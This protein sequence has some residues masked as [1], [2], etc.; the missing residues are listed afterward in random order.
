MPTSVELPANFRSI[1][2]LSN[3]VDSSLSTVST[4][5]QAA[6][7]LGLTNI[8]DSLHSFDAFLPP[9]GSPPQSL[10]S[11]SDAGAIASP[12]HY[13]NQAQE[14][15]GKDTLKS[16]STL[17]PMNE[18][19]QKLMDPN[20]EQQK[21]LRSFSD[22]LSNF[23]L[24]DIPPGEANSAKGLG[25]AHEAKH[26]PDVGIAHEAKYAREIGIGHEAKHAPDFKFAP[27][28]KYRAPDFKQAPEFKFGDTPL[29]KQTPHQAGD[30]KIVRFDDPGFTPKISG[31]Q[32]DL[33]PGFS[34]G[35]F[36]EADRNMD[37]GFTP[38]ALPEEVIGDKW[39]PTDPGFTPKIADGPLRD[40]DPGFMPPEMPGDA[41]SYKPVFPGDSGFTPKLPTDANADKQ[42]PSDPG[43]TP[44]AD[45]T[46]DKA[47]PSDPG[48]IPA[49]SNSIGDDAQRIFDLQN[50][51]QNIVSLNKQVSEF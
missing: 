47:L 9:I 4:G 3:A 26:S 5:I 40:I 11:L 33:D 46:A 31:E 29:D 18:V 28:Y 41:I 27:E 6:Q 22:L 25:I 10:H 19:L 16:F 1:S 24:Q 39:V 2:E 12:D 23:K 30:A 51:L 32:R 45:A 17:A 7:N 20:L 48:F 34:P 8:S 42:F 43:F 15:V 49:Q 14:F 38:P 36:G 35:R 21:S 50:T 13:L 44:K 37:I